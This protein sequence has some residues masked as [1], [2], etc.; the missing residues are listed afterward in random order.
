M[1][2][3]GPGC[4]LMFLISGGLTYEMA[5]NTGGVNETA[6]IQWCDDT[7]TSIAGAVGTAIGTGSAN[8]TAMQAVCTSGAAISARAYAGGG[9]SDWFL[10]S[11]DELNE[12]CKYSRNPTTP[13]SPC[14]G[15]QDGAFAAGAFGFPSQFYFSSSQF[16]ATNAWDQSFFSGSQGGILKSTLTS[17]VRPVRAF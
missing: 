9:Q 6:G 13:P 14:A 16:D 10:P 8:T 1:G 3:T 12:M 15:G 4:G 5:P 17:R 7:T 11:K 2:D